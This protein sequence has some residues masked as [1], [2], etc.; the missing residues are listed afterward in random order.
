MQL[1]FHLIL[2]LI[3]VDTETDLDRYCCGRELA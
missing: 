2:K 3:E 1:L